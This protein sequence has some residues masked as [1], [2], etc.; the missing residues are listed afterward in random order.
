VKTLGEMLEIKDFDPMKIDVQELSEFIENIK[1]TGDIIDENHA[2]AVATKAL[3]LARYCIDLW[4]RGVRLYGYRDTVKKAELA[5]AADRSGKVSDTAK[6]AAAPMD[7]KYIAY[8]NL[9]TDAEAF[10]LWISKMHEN[11]MH[12][13]FMARGIMKG[14]AGEMKAANYESQNSGGGITKKDERDFLES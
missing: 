5:A 11:C 10:V 9:T 1:S 6:K 4:A 2:E 8:S 14:Y 3:R 7:A 13:H 12:I